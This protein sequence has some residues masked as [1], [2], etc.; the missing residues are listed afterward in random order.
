[1]VAADGNAGWQASLA[2][3]ERL[4]E[5]PPV[6]G[7]ALSVAVSIQWLRFVL[8]PQREELRSKTERLEYARHLFATR[9]G[10]EAEGWEVRLIE[11]TAP[12]ARLACAMPPGLVADLQALCARA[13]VTLRRVEPLA[14]ALFNAHDAPLSTGRHWFVVPEAGAAFVALLDG[15]AWQGVAVRRAAI[16]SAADLAGL[17]EAE[18]QFLGVEERVEQVM[19]GAREGLAQAAEEN[20]YRFAWLGAAGTQESEQAS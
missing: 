10:A 7:A 17:L 3:L 18:H 19:A 14:I 13:G 4:F 16:G 2:A 6:R 9:F 20:G 8:V 11:G 5:V 15:G 12:G 1:M